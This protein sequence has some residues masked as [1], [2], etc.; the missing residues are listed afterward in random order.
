MNIFYTLATK[1]N[2]AFP[3]PTD[4]VNDATPLDELSQNDKLIQDLQGIY[5]IHITVM[6]KK[7]RKLVCM[8]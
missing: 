6:C 2:I 8:E 1:P 7:Y 5:I 4:S 3:E